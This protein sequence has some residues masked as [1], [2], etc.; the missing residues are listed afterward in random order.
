MVARQLSDE[1][2]MKDS[3]E[4]LQEHQTSPPAEK[5]ENH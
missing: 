2:V 3:V 1:Q 5:Q 4:D